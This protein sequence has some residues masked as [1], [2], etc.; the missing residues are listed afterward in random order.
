MLIIAGPG[1]GCRGEGLPCAQTLPSLTTADGQGR[2]PAHGAPGST[3]PGLALSWVWPHAG[4]PKLP[5][6]LGGVL[7]W[8]KSFCSVHGESA[9]LGGALWG[10]PGSPLIPRANAAGVRGGNAV[11]HTHQPAFP[12]QQ[13]GMQGGLPPKRCPMEVWTVQGPHQSHAARDSDCAGYRHSDCGES[14]VL[15]DH[16]GFGLYWDHGGSRD[17][18]AAGSEETRGSATWPTRHGV[19]PGWAAL[20]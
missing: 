13:R 15:V 17:C 12:S 16:G 19:P 7:R 2:V 4:P 3:P 9:R 10:S 18:P 8:G 5:F 14:R 20:V 6:Q 1:Q 11:T